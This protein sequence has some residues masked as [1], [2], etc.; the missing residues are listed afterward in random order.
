VTVQVVVPNPAVTVMNSSSM[1]S[2]KAVEGKPVAEATVTVVAVA[3]RA[4]VSVVFAPWPTRQK[5][6]LDGVRSA[7]DE[8]PLSRVG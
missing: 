6:E 1:R 5:Y 8:T 2:T 3:V 7:T 4:P